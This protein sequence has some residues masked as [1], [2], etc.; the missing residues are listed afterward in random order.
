[1]SA[2]VVDRRASVRE[3]AVANRVCV[4]WWVGDQIY[5]TTGRMLN[6]SEGGAL[7]V[8]DVTPPLGQSVWLHVEAPAVTDEVG[9]RVARLGQRN[10]VGLSFATPCPYD[11]YLAA[12]LGINPCG[13]LV[14]H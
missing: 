2:Q 4:E 14:E 6:I 1:M 3:P 13:V 7:V 8:A 5:S 9:A 10:E 11:L 12:T